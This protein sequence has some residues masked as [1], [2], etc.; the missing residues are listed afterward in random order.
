MQVAAVNLATIIML[1]SPTRKLLQVLLLLILTL[2]SAIGDAI[3]AAQQHPAAPD[4]LRLNLALGNLPDQ[5]Y[6]EHG[7]GVYGPGR[8]INLAVRYVVE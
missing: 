1:Y 7:S 4:D 5:A 8:G 2:L 3:P 6:K